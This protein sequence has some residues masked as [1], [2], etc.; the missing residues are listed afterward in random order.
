MSDLIKDLISN[1][2]VLDYTDNINKNDNTYF[3][4]DEWNVV[5]YTHLNEGAS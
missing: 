4:N 3:W 5:N 2:S 1:A